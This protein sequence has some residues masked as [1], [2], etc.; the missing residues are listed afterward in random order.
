MKRFMIR[1]P[2]MYERMREASFSP[3]AVMTLFIASLLYL[4]Y[5]LIREIPAFIIDLIH[6]SGQ[7]V[8]SKEQ[9]EQ[10]IRDYVSAPDT[11]LAALALTSILLVLTLVYVRLIEKRP[12]S[13]IGLARP[14]LGRVAFGYALGLA[15]FAA[16]LAPQMIYRQAAFTGFV[17]VAALFLPAYIIKAFSE[18]AFFRGYMLSSLCE[19][20]GAIPAVLLSSAVFS[21]YHIMTQSA[22]AL[23][24]AEAFTR[25]MMLALLALR[26]G[27]LW[28]SIGINAAWSFAAGLFSP[29]ALNDLRTS[30]AAFSA[31][32]LD[33]PVFIAIEIAA[34]AVII[35]AGE[36]RLAVPLSESRALYKKAA[37][38]ARETLRGRR[39][40]DGVPLLERAFKIAR[41]V[42]SDEAK[43]AALL[44][45]V[46]A[47]TGGSAAEPTGYG[48]R[49]AHVLKALSD[50]PG[51]TS[52]DPIAAEVSAASIRCTA[53]LKA[54]YIRRATS[55]NGQLQCPLLRREI[56][57]TRCAEAI[58]TVDE[59]GKEAEFIS[60]ALCKSCPRRMRISNRCG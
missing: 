5:F 17:P 25:G 56:D 18:E 12:L 11:M 2:I 39:G 58:R 36:N 55:V 6:Y 29:V 34:S 48:A 40:D 24:I 31:A 7:T 28:G 32:G 21:L 26:A 60:T 42:E 50:V 47:R 52:R 59:G 27:S 20:S 3:G 22:E 9:A 30:Y 49:I 44:F 19:K 16:A 45:A 14:A 54:K 35:F 33:M 38:L 46:S 41:N 13:T 4:V 57:D 23:G 15:L 10:V 43:A 8:T 37:R 51:G 1:K 53:E